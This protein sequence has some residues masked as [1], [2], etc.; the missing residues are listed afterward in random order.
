MTET[1]MLET[2]A[3]TLAYDVRGPLPPADG[4]PV[5]MM[6]GAPM[7]AS[8]FTS[9]AAHFGD[10]TVVTYDPRGMG[11]ST[12]N[13][14]STAQSAEQNAEDIHAIIAELG[15]A[16]VELFGS[17]GGAIS[18][19]VLSTAY[20]DDVSVLVAHEPPLTGLLPDADKVDA[21]ERAVQAVYQDKGWGHGMAAFLAMVSWKGEFT[22]EALAAPP[23]DP[24]A[25]GL[26]TEDDGSR[27]DP[28]LSGGSDDVT[29][30]DLDLDDL[31]ASPVRIVVAVGAESEGLITG[32]TSA[33]LAEAL[34]QE[35]AVFPGGHGGFLGGEFG[36]QGDPEAFAVRLRAVLDG[37]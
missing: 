34:G 23:P 30:E 5:L 22:D 15:I 25:F 3:V 21:A 10:R 27:D 32:R 33:V 35:A 2:P 20:P 14:G 24:A 12:L 6:V 8:G 26:P 31:N 9:L 7:D 29:P 4:R 19:L 17:S 36:Q 1:R 18:G 11:R 37:Q 16:P 13:D 28:L